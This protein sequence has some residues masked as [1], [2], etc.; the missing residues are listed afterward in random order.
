MILV[1]DSGATKTRWGLFDVSL[2]QNFTTS[3]I[4]PYFQSAISVAEL[5]RNELPLASFQKELE[6]VYFYGAGCSGEIN[7]R[8]VKEALTTL[9]GVKVDVFGDLQGAAR[10][11]FGS[12]PGIVCILGTGASVGRY[13]GVKVV[14]DLPSLGFIS[15][16]WCSGAS[17]GKSLLA[18]YFLRKLP[19]NLATDFSAHESPD[20]NEFMQRLYREPYPNRYLASFVPFLCRHH[21]SEYVAQLLAKEYDLLYSNYLSSY[22][23]EGLPVGVVGSVGYLF[24]DFFMPRLQRDF[25]AVEGFVQDP[26]PRLAS[27]HI[28]NK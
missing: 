5:L 14:Q 8:W 28:S 23:S 17:L 22:A 7:N 13:D 11:L 12:R 9:F 16:D 4:N 27:Y 2:K 19:D 10:A 20:Y 21:S 24:R 3:G 6:A 26:L 15:G 18:D 1:A 25:V